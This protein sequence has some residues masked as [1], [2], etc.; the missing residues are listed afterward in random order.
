MS[1]IQGASR[2]TVQDENGVEPTNNRAE[3]ALRFAVP[4]EKTQQRHSE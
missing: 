2:E 4:M 3:R 1:G